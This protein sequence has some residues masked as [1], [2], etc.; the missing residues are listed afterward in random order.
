MRVTKKNRYFFSELQNAVVEIKPRHFMY[1]HACASEAEALS[2]H[3]KEQIKMLQ[4]KIFGYR[5][6]IKKSEIHIE[7]CKKESANLKQS[8]KIIIDEHPE[9]DI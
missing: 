5:E 3:Y 8:L 4:G 2:K 9:Y 6:T 1:K 7:N